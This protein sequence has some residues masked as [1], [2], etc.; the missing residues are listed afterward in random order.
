MCTS[1]TYRKHD[2]YFGRN[3]DVD[4]TFNEKV[5]ITPR[6]Y[7]FQLKNGANYRTSYALIGMAAVVQDYPLYYEAA[8]E[9]GL[10]MA[11]LNFPGNAVYQETKPDKENIAVFELIPWILGQA[12]NLTEAKKL[13][14]NLNLT[15]VNFSEG[16]PTSPLHFMLSDKTGSI[17]V[18][19]R[20][21]GLEIFDDPYEVM[22][23]NPPF[24]YHMW[25]IQRYRNLDPKN[26]EN[27]FSKQY[28]LKPFAVG[29]G[30]DGL[31]GDTS[32]TSRFVRAAFN[33]TNSYSE[34]TEDANV[35]QFFH[36]LDSVAMVKGP[37]I[38]D[39]G[40]Y[41]ITLYSCCINAD[42]GI[43]Y[44]KTYDN[45]QITAIKMK[46]ENMTGKKL[47]IYPLRNSQQIYF[48]N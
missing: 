15:N 47:T 5:C 9:K 39:S 42:Q 48:E 31:P 46:P 40:K 29:M 2:L 6:Q 1:I 44:Y 22:A 17:V 3:L 10:S 33:L 4:F 35:G 21:S 26:G 28:E 11:G 20:E 18:E 13:F 45:N 14:S 19:P 8:N 38:T 16:F 7:L 36:I 43:Y 34:D 32:S 12:A 25:N 27:H 37:T 41:D 23:N 30:A 24:E